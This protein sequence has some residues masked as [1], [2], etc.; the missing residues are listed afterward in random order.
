MNI[1]LNQAKSFIMTLALTTIVTFT[2]S[3]PSVSNAAEGTAD[4]IDI[5]SGNGWRLE[6]STGRKGGWLWEA[7][8]RSGWSKTK[9]GAK[10]A[11][12]AAKKA[13]KK[14][15]NSNGVRDLNEP[16]CNEPGVVC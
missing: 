11:A 1:K 10:K 9:K 12:R 13:A 15:S 3:H 16:G 7:G 6:E 4:G 8:G 2:L 5:I 14:E